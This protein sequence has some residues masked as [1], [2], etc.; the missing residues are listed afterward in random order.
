MA[1]SHQVTSAVVH[2]GGSTRALAPRR[3]LLQLILG[4]AK[5]P[6]VPPPVLLR[7]RPLWASQEHFSVRP[8]P[9][10]PVSMQLGN[11]K[12]LARPSCQPP[13]SVQWMDRRCREAG[14]RAS[15][16]V[17]VPPG[18]VWPQ[19]GAGELWQPVVAH[20][21]PVAAGPGTRAQRGSALPAATGVAHSHGGFMLLNIFK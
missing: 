9:K 11:Q 19:L 18:A 10:A 20:N 13:A 8:D 14:T 4:C 12:L 6:A 2:R 1:V 3:A 16:P 5:A 21:A 15:L 17:P 7:C